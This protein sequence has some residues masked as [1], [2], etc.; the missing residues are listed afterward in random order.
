MIYRI[1]L[2]YFSFVFFYFVLFNNSYAQADSVNVNV[3]TN[4]EIVNDL[5]NKNIDE[6][7]NFLESD[8]IYVDINEENSSLRNFFNNKLRNSLVEYSL[9][10]FNAN[11]TYIPAKLEIRNLTVNVS[12]PRFGGTGVLGNKSFN[13]I[14][15]ISFDVSYNRLSDNSV[16]YTKRI[17]DKYSDEVDIS[18]KQKIENSNYSFLSSNLPEDNFFNKYLIPTGLIVISAVTIVLFFAIR[19]N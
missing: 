8:T 4:D 2:F 16:I 14:I 17:E 19:S 18:L 1:I 5:I 13:R 11:L 15:S 9:R 7:K 6:L 12:Y 10:P 3:K